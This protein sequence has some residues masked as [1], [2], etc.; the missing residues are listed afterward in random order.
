[1]QQTHATK[2]NAAVSKRKKMFTILLMVIV[3]ITV[4]VSGYWFFYARY[5]ISTDNAYVGAEISQVTPSIG[6]TVKSIAV[7]DTQKVCRGDVLVVIDDTDAQLAFAKAQADVALAQANLVRATIDWDRR[8]ALVD[9]GSVSGEE[10]TTAENAHKVAQAMYNA[11][12]AVL[13]QARVD[14]ARTIIRAPVGGVVSKRMVQLGQRVQI[15]NPLLSIVPIDSVHVDAN[16]KEVQLRKVKLGDPV[17][18][19]A[20]IYGEKIEYHGK[21]AGFAGMTGSASAVIPAQNATGNWIKVVQRLPVRIELDPQE[22][23][24]YPLQVGLS[25]EVTIDIS[26]RYQ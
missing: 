18:L 14:L 23:A 20:D 9:S 1:M 15:G 16:F 24:A 10:L 17:M 26:G 7:T 2:K 13:D 19:I 22:L 21:V 25:M 8:K 3:S 11:D 4:L 12:K 5:S 6:G